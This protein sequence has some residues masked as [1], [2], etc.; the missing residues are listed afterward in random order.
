[1]TLSGKLIV[2][3]GA[4]SG[5]GAETAAVLTAAGAR[6]IGL[7]REETGDNVAQFIAVDL[8]DPASIAHAAGDAAELL[9]FT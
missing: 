5:I 8:S 1:M 3:T 7:D 9:I 2:V 4:A 6:V